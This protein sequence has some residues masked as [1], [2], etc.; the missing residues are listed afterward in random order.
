[1]IENRTSNLIGLSLDLLNYSSNWLEHHFFPLL[2]EL[3]RVH[4]LVIEL[5]HP[6]F[7]FERSN[8]ELRTLFDPSLS[9]RYEFTFFISNQLDMLNI[10][11][12]ILEPT[13]TNSIIPQW[14][15]II[16]R[17]QKFS[18]TPCRAL[19]QKPQVAPSIYHN[20]IWMSNLSNRHKSHRCFSM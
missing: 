1:M 9:V 11:L 17:S 12:L 16:A 19:V 8:I 20:N 4:L 18:L 7:G 6:I 3:E 15:I 10:W 5:E 13:F 14:W 2:N